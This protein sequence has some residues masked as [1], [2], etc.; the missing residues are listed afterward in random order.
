MDFK[1]EFYEMLHDSRKE[2]EVLSKSIDKVL[3]GHNNLT[4]L[5]AVMNILMTIVLNSGCQK[6]ICSIL[7]EILKELKNGNRNKRS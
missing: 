5:M 4:N 1:K 7:I 3:D 6:S 2:I